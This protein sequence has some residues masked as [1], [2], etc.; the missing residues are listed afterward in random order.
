MAA[1]NVS[2]NLSIHAQRLLHR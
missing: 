2:Y 1:H